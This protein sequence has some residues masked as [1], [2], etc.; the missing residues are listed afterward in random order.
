M[1]QETL[2]E[3]PRPSSSAPRTSAPSSRRSSATSTAS[4]SAALAWT[5]TSS[6]PSRSE[7]LEQLIDEARRD[8]PNPGNREERLPDEGNAERLAVFLAGD[9]PTVIYFG[10]LLEQGRASALR[11]APG[12]EDARTVVVG[13]GDYREE[14][15]WNGAAAALFSGRSTTGTCH[16]MPLGDV[17]VVPS[18]FPEAFGMVAAEAA[19]RR[20]AA[21]CAALRAS[22][23]SP[24]GRRMITPHTGTPLT[25][26]SRRGLRQG[27]S[28]SS[29]L[30][31]P[32][33]AKRSPRR[34]APR[35]WS[36]GAARSERLL[37]PLQRQAIDR[38]RWA[39]R[40]AGL[41]KDQGRDD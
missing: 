27:P 7:R 39:R 26:P 33:T 37:D 24:R 5:W 8:P 19:A 17:A 4:T 14:L 36:A 6:F 12:H 22:R 2:A 35:P 3:A 9:E 10:K 40:S 25:Q 30:S 32:P 31:L 16:L 18:I 21:R 29:T 13:F 11:C 34:E 41:M 1:G 38:P 15:E 20:A 23:R 28:A